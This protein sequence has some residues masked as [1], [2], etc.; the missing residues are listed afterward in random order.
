MSPSLPE[1]PD[2]AQLKRRAKELLHAHARREVSA[3]ARLTARHPRLAGLAEREALALP[4]R[5]ADAQLV[6][7]REHGFESWSA[8]KH[9]VQCAAR[10]A[11]HQPHP[12]FGAALAALD[13]GDAP[14]LAALLARQPELARARTNLAPPFDYFT[15][16]TLL[17]HVAWNPS[18]AAPVPRSVV[19]LARLLL[20]HGA[21]V[22]ALTLGPGGGTTLGLVLTSKAASDADASGALIELLLARGATLDLAGSAAVIPGLGRRD[23]LDLALSN[24]APRAAEKLLELGAR[25]DLCSAAA[26]GRMD[27]LRAAFD[28]RGRLRAAPRRA[29]RF[30]SARDALGLA[31]LFAYVNRRDEAVDFLLAKDGNWSM[32][33]VGNGTALHRAASDGDLS[34]VR[35]LVAR[36]ADVSDRANP[37]GATPLSWAHHAGQH[38][39]FA[40]LRASCAID[41]FDAVCFDLGEHVVQRLDEDPTSINARRD[42]WDVPRST[43]LYWTAHPDAQ[44]ARAEE[45]G[46]EPLARLLLARGAAVNLVAGDGRTALDVARAGGAHRVAALL[47]AHGGEPSA[48][49]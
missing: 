25:A 49:P 4:V 3:A 24:H 26:L 11:R 22:D 44:R 32:T 28:A 34:M 30:L 48:K 42:Q 1:R 16:A 20:E 39:V 38:E 17:H 43:P 19:A 15:G 2:L 5:L 36:G 27:L 33:G 10:V 7:A 41:L 23:P 12:G 6:I 14:A 35:R 13:A 45:P 46:N 21:E 29:G 8:L 47:E 37:F 31:L 18:R 9:V 40:W